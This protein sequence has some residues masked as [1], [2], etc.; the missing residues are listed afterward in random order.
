MTVSESKNNPVFTSVWDVSI[1]VVL[2]VSLQGIEGVCL[3]VT[4]VQF[5]GYSQSFVDASRSLGYLTTQSGLF[6]FRFDTLAFDKSDNDSKDRYV[7]CQIPFVQHVCPSFVLWKVCP[8]TV[9][10]YM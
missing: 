9:G 6:V 3:G 7:S 10:F 4:L 2:R 8:F 1:P 5:L